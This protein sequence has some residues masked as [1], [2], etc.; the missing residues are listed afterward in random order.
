V[1]VMGVCL[2]EQGGKGC[3]GVS[4]RRGGGDAVWEGRKKGATG[5]NEQ[6]MKESHHLVHGTLHIL[7]A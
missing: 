5:M 7:S 4:E 1:V 6:M 2:G 3:G